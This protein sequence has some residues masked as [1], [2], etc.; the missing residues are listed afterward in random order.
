MRA[1]MLPLILTLFGLGAGIGA[2]WFLKPAQEAP[3]EKADAPS[4]T[5]KE[6]KPSDAGPS[7]A[8]MK[9]PDKKEEDTNGRSE[10]VK[11]NNQFVVPVVSNSSVSSLVVMSLSLEVETGL[12]EVVFQREPKLRD[13]LLQVM[14]DHAN[15]GG[16]DGAFTEAGNLDILRS[17]L[18]DMARQILPKGVFGVLIVDLARQDL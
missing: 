16:F 17:G 4:A 14:F 18:T 6:M 5:D 2:G 9:V 13:A 3:K 11:L 8:G 15:I 1:I 10:F 7:A 12:R